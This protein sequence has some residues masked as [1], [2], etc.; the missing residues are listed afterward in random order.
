M[1]RIIARRAVIAGLAALLLSAAP[2]PRDLRLDNAEDLALVTGSPWVV[3]S[4]MA[5]GAHAQGALAAIDRRDGTIRRLYPEG[6]ITDTPGGGSVGDCPGMPAA[7]TFQP[8][9]IAYVAKGE[10]G[11][12]L[13]VVNHGGR[14]S[15]EFFDL[16]LTP[17]PRLRW[18]GCTIVP[19]GARGNGVA[20]VADGTLYMTNMG[21][22]LDGS[23]PLSDIG[24]EVVAWRADRGWRTVPGSAIAAPN[25][26]VATADG[27]QIYV[28]SWSGGAVVALTPDGNAPPRA[29]RLDFLPDNLRW[30]DRGTIL[31]VGHRTSAKAVRDCY[32]SRAARCTIPSAMAEID[33][34]RLA[35]RCTRAVALDM[36][37]VAL[38]VGRE[39]WIGA[40]R[41]DRII[42]DKPCTRR[43]T[44]G[45]RQAP[46]PKAA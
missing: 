15:I 37:T 14:E 35:V 41:G 13:Y 1:T 29:L 6:G 30:S 21:R 22:P 40:A 7:Q 23:A 33:P 5:G 38:P 34:A 42:R 16:A 46:S 3:A 31:A 43:A 45:V 9:G 36:A 2:S 39:L 27:G 20:A 24:G 44:D 17:T 4:S 8:H 18:A 26:I 10:A 11:G 25:G 32:A 12:R 19:T 28:A